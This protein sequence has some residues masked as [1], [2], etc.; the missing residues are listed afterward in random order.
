[1]LTGAT[2]YISNGH[3]VVL[4]KNGTKMLGEITGSGCLVGSCVATYCAVAAEIA[5]T[6]GDDMRGC[7]VPGDMLL[8]AVTG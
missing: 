4:L 8:G 7:L 3:E 2:D 5:K 6:R 1:M